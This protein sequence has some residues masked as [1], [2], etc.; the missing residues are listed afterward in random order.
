MKVSRITAFL[1]A[2]LAVSPAAI[3]KTRVY[4]LVVAQNRSL[5]P[6]VKPLR[7]ADDDGVKDWE[8]LSLYA[9][10]SSLFVLLDDETARMHPDAS[11]SAEVPR[12]QAIF[13]R[14][15]QYNDLMAADVARGDDPELFFVYAGHGD[16]D[17]AG[18]GYVNLFDGKLTRGE[19]F[20]D[21]V[22]PSK[23]RFVHVIIDACKSYFMVN[24][25]GG[26]RWLDDQVPAEEDRSDQQLKAFLAAEDLS[27]YPRAG[28][29]VATS[30]DQ[31]THE[32]A[33]Y[34]SGIL[35]HE[36][37]SALSGAADVN[38]DGRIEYSELRAFLAAA[39]ARV[40]N[41]EARIEAFARPPALDRHHA[42]V[43]LRHATGN[44]RF[45]HFAPG[46]AGR[47]HIEDDRGVRWADLNKELAAGFD[48]MV[49][50][51]HGYYVMRGDAQAPDETEE[52][53][54]RAAGGRRIDLSSLK[55]RP[56][57]IASR[58]ALDQTFRQDLYKVPY[59]RGFYDGYVATSGDLPVDEGQ[60]FIVMEPRKSFGRHRLGLGY[61]MTTPAIGDRVCHNADNTPFSC[62]GTGLSHGVDV[63]YAYNV[64]GP[65][66]I[67]LAG[68]VGYGSGESDQAM[69]RFA[70][71][72]FWG[73]QYLPAPWV[74]LRLDA[75]LGWQ[76]LSGQ[77]LLG[78]DMNN[79]PVYANGTETR[80]LRF[81]AAGGLGFHLANNLWL[82]VR[83]GLALDG[84]YPQ[85]DLN[86]FTT[87]GGF[88]NAGVQ[89]Q[90]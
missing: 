50:P 49:S 88:L 82:L 4:A 58:G 73:A 83:G 39:N 71:L 85:G 33:R 43:D 37:R 45:L 57:A 47:F 63:R 54:V 74:A 66:E 36:L 3:A 40:R 28:V 55:W 68:Q 64:W 77:Y 6:G 11:H 53:E 46:L 21:V 78:R 80:S 86:S 18:Q 15:A 89:F 60:P 14:L 51:G 1:A 20:H 59:G 34:Q 5:D 79:K 23:A 35:S 52:T 48:V 69:T 16:V 41:P 30:G 90:L 19:L 42:L 32:W 8:L 10:R 9:D 62:A 76:V 67:G 75:G 81:E 22:A 27:N 70:A 65:L 44:T 12:K 31:D 7:Y 38:G 13:D 25:R 72:A 29:I 26:K 84:V 17:A 56:R 2:L 24:S 61:L 87:A